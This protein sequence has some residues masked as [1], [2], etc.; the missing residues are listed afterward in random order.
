MHILFECCHPFTV[1]TQIFSSCLLTG[2]NL[3]VQ[4]LM[5]SQNRLHLPSVPNESAIMRSRKMALKRDVLKWLDK[6]K[7]GWSI[8]RVSTFGVKFVQTLTDCLW[9]IDSH[10]D[11]LQGRACQVPDKFNEFQGYNKPEESRHR[12]REAENMCAG[13]LDNLCGMLNEHLMQISC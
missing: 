8:D 10:H 11:T 5:A 4:V 3:H 2:V 6:K 13:M 12:R 7:V 9:Y 1:A